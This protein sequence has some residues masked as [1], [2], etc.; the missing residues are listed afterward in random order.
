MT[1]STP[2]T[3]ALCV[4]TRCTSV[5]QF[6]A[7]FHRFCGEDQTFF[8]ATMT[9]RP[10]GL[11][12][13]FSIQLADKQP[14][15][16]GFCIVLDA[17]QTPAN[18]YKRPGI[19]LGIKRL[20]AES[21]VVFDRLKA[22]SRAP[23]T[24]AEATPAPGPPPLRAGVLATPTAPSTAPAAPSIAV[25][26][27]PSTAPPRPPTFPL[28]SSATPQ[29]FP[30]VS[31]RARLPSL[32]AIPPQMPVLPAK[33][34]LPSVPAPPVAPPAHPPSVA[35]AAPATSAVE[36][37]ARPAVGAASPRPAAGPA[38]RRSAVG[39]V[40]ARP[41]VGSA[42]GPAS[43]RPGV[44][45]TPVQPAIEPASPRPVEVT[46]F[47]VALNVD[48]TPP[49]VNDVEFKPVQLVPRIRSDPRIVIDPPT[50]DEPPV[51]R[52][53]PA[54]I[55]DRPADP[56]P[57]GVHDTLASLAALAAPLLSASPPSA[58]RDLRTPGSALVL[59]AN[60][61][62]N[63]SD[64]SL[65][66]FVD[67]TLYEEA[68][69]VF[70]PG[71]DD[72]GW[73]EM[74]LPGEPARPTPPAI[75]PAMPFDEP[76]EL[77]VRSVGNTVSLAVGA[78][79]PGRPQ[80]AYTSNQPSY[81]QP[82]YEHPTSGSPASEHRS[83]YA[84][85]RHDPRSLADTPPAGAEPVWSEP[86]TASYAV[87]F[88]AVHT[89]DTQSAVDATT[90]VHRRAA[91][92]VGLPELSS[93]RLPPDRRRW[94]L[95]GST[96]V[97]AI[98]VAFVMA[99]LARGPLPAPLAAS[100]ARASR[101]RA[102]VPPPPAAGAEPT[103]AAAP[104]PDLAGAADPPASGD[105]DAKLA[106]AEDA[107]A[108]T[109]AIAVVGSGPCRFTISTVPAASIVKLDDTLV[110]S[111]PIT[112]QATCDKHSIDVAHAR[113]QAVTKSVT[114]TADDPQQ[115]EIRLPRPIHAVTITSLP[116]GAELSIDGRRAGTT[117]T[118]VQ[119]MGFATVNLTL[120]KPGFP[121][122]SRKVYSKLPQDRVFVKLTK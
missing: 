99:R 69:N 97:I 22:A 113:Y 110:G 94:L 79:P 63:L 35:G 24:I 66:G 118:V 11:E 67:C 23:A 29:A 47:Q 32:R 75:V 56:E 50:P 65:E 9:S 100:H 59:P 122:V 72:S 64:E 93:L 2:K 53:D 15:L 121:S 27:Q 43:S 12:T 89:D 17:W 28:R 62:Q 6:V 115:L 68:V 20:T 112:I 102:A 4:A 82:A 91:W 54:L 34:G 38:A 103:P 51:D 7:T 88:H 57:T 10:I 49:S 25:S 85:S 98:I 8:V 60:P 44:E 86:S 30:A 14:V 104:D 95:I 96:A 18:R 33:L 26:S 120:S 105:P 111:S 16:R 52:R 83:S 87:T 106:L 101:D 5:D 3:R 55:V 40:P 108:P 80:P 31:P 119:M 13:A 36:P 42:S 71:V 58:A 107:V 37:A 41:A 77:T 92:L 84:P 81:E 116:P 19:R 70:H 114:L 45:S 78:D 73:D 46:R 109:G 21:Q 117:P 1:T 76:P 90:T 39:A 48:A 74:S 61:L